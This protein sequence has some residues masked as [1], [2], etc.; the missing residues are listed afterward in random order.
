MSK[1]KTKVKKPTKR[2]TKKSSKKLTWL[3]EDEYMKER[4]EQESKAV[5]SK[6]S[7][8]NGVKPFGKVGTESVLK[9]DE[10]TSKHVSDD[11]WYIN[12]TPD[13]NDTFHE[14]YDPEATNKRVFSDLEE[15][16]DD[17]YSQLLTPEQKAD[18]SLCNMEAEIASATKDY[19][20]AKRKLMVL[21]AAYYNACDELSLDTLDL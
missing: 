20:T 9:E 2:S 21:K 19:L 15:V 5:E 16:L 7:D 14:D 18:D 17:T 11:S 13:L 6:S 3:N 10:V 12:W 8:W 1:S 4:L